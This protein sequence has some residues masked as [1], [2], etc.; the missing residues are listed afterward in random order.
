MCL[1]QIYNVGFTVSALSHLL[2]FISLVHPSQIAHFPL[3]GICLRAGSHAHSLADI[4]SVTYSAASFR[5]QALLYHMSLLCSIYCLC[6]PLSSWI[7]LSHYLLSQ[8]LHLSL[9]STFL[10]VHI[11]WLGARCCGI[12]QYQKG[13]FHSPWVTSSRKRKKTK[14][15]LS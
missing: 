13:E 2:L 5:K 11:P 4:P 10:K 3:N 6:C 7:T 12:H 8:G 9:F 1:L 14:D 15:F